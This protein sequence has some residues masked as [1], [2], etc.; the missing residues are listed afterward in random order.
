MLYRRD[1]DRQQGNS[2]A[3]RL[4]AKIFLILK[5]VLK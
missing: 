1:A 2:Y 5:E 4:A 3:A